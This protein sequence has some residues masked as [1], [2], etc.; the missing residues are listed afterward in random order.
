MRDKKI[1]SENGYDI[2]NFSEFHNL[3]NYF[4]H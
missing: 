2:I 1:N 4:S 3:E